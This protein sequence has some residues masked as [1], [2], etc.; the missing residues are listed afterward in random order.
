[1]A[2]YPFTL[3]QLP[4]DIEKFILDDQF[5]Q[6]RKAHGG[7]AVNSDDHPFLEELRKEI[8]KF[9]EFFAT[10]AGRTPCDIEVH[11][12]DR[13]IAGCV[14]LT[15][16]ETPN[17]DIENRDTWHSDKEWKNNFG[18]KTSLP[19]YILACNAAHEG[20][21]ATQTKGG[22]FTQD[23]RTMLVIAKTL[24]DNG[25]QNPYYRNNFAE[26]YARIAEAKFF[27]AAWERIRDIAPEKLTTDTYYSMLTSLHTHLTNKVD[28]QTMQ[29]LNNRNRMFVAMPSK[30]YVELARAFPGTHPRFAKMATLSFLSN[31]A[32]VN[33]LFQGAIDEMNKVATAI[34]KEIKD[35]EAKRQA[36]KDEAK[37]AE[38]QDMQDKIQDLIKQ[39][40]IPVL[41]ELPSPL[42]D[43]TLRLDKPENIEAY[44]TPSP[45]KYNLCV[46]MTPG[47]GLCAWY[48]LSPRTRPY[49][50]STAAEPE[51][52][53]NK[54]YV[55]AHEDENR[56][57]DDAIIEEEVK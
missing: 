21:H 47:F 23:Q 35:I 22:D 28:L 51:H 20:D 15:K 38:Q 55:L 12:D 57:Q 9:E 19:G 49:S 7:D 18:Y 40:N 27:L 52:A 39:H 53:P 2:K 37:R 33:E 45:D 8:R 56:D 50:I 30:K 29:A 24:Y 31:T 32:K 46:A 4:P 25:A 16:D 48:D 6:F 13:P 44:L 34:E 14:D 3:P 36:I 26:V 11:F 42:P 41:N 1:M 10:E 5:E 54:E 43:I 17:H